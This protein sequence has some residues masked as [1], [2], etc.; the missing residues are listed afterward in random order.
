MGTKIL[1][2]CYCF[3]TQPLMQRFRL[4]FAFLTRE[5]L[6]C[7]IKFKQNKKPSSLAGN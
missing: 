6:D 1:T 2:I 4:S 7:E 5:R 3:R